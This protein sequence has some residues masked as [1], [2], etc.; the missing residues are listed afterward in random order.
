MIYFLIP[1]FNEEKNIPE[2]ASNLKLVLN[3]KSKHYVLVDDCSTDETI[4]II[5]ENFQ[6]G[7]YT[8]LANPI[9]SGPGYSFNHGFEFIL[10]HAKGQ[11]DIVITLEGDNT[12]DLS[13]APL[14]VELIE[15]WSFGLVLSSVY[16]QGGGF[17]Q[18]SF[19][20]KVISLVANQLLRF[21]FDVKVLTLSSFYRAYDLAVI[22]NIK[23]KY[24]VIIRESGFICA[25]EILVKSIHVNTRIIEIP[26][27]LRSD[28]RKGKSKM[29]IIKTSLEY[30]R[31]LMT[32]WM[33]RN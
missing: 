5:K 30:V 7:F 19:F 8:V 23:L 28:K 9:N 14:M 11:G 6:E 16:S 12:S 27:L 26:M 22:K 21:I 17:S 4:Q 10:S 29:K 33:K 13:L 20:R 25:L 15:K 3:D 1:V 18:T 32:Y 31:F 2:L 24:D